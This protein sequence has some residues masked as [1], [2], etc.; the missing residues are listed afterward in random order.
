MFRPRL[1]LYTNETVT[2]M[3]LSCF[4]FPISKCLSLSDCALYLCLIAF[5][6]L[7]SPICLLLPSF[8]FF[9]SLDLSRVFFQ[10]LPF[11]S[12]SDPNLLSFSSFCHFLSVVFL[13]SPPSHLVPLVCYCHI[14]V[15]LLNDRITGHYEVVCLVRVL[16]PVHY[17]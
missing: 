9:P 2:S 5:S 7:S 6:L 10:F 13:S 14:S 15:F 4:A 11:V 1:S 17:L 12:S 8:S 16:S 3:L